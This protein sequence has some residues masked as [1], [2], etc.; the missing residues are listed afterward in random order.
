M[1]TQTRE[2]PKSDDQGKEVRLS[3][4]ACNRETTHTIVRSAEYVGN[5]ED[6][7]F[8]VTGWDE[9]QVVECKGCQAMSF[10]HS[11]R[12]TE[13]ASYDP[14]TQQ[15]VLH[16]RVAVYPHRLPGRHTIQDTYLLPPTIR[17]AYEETVQALA[18]DMPVLAGVGIRAIV[19]SVCKDRGAQGINL[20]QRI[21]D[22]IAQGALTKA[23]AEILHS[24]RVMGNAAAHE[25]KPHSISAL[26]IA[27]DVVEHTLNGLYIIPQR[28]SA[29][30]K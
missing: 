26:S 10:R 12:D 16:E 29:L 17:R 15:E 21:D 25:V 8:G 19:E 14:Y 2:G 9:Y 3:C 11:S 1:P 7:D 27:M 13:D 24:L 28:A 6:G 20:E 22:L 4:S 18:A 5:Y 30:P 23:G